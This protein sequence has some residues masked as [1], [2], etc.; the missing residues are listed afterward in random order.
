MG[1]KDSTTLAPK[2]FEKPKFVYRHKE[3]CLSSNEAKHVYKAIERGEHVTPMAIN[4]ESNQVDAHNHGDSD[5][6]REA[7]FP[8]N[9]YETAL[10]QDVDFRLIGNS[11]HILQGSAL[12][13][14]PI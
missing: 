12:K 8:V 4:P 10:T 11:E 5:I 14:S 9:P 2:M 6:T 13:I 3:I 7:A 1:L